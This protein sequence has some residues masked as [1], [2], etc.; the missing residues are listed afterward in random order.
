MTLGRQLAAVMR[1]VIV[2]IAV[3]FVPA[4]AQAH[5]GQVLAT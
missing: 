3:L 4:L 1:A 2:M 5:A